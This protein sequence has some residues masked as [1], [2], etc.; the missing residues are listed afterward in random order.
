MTVHLA[1]TALE[2]DYAVTRR[3]PGEALPYW[4]AGPGLLSVTQAP[5][6]VSILCLADRVPA[7]EIA[8][9]GWQAVQVDT[10]A[11]LDQPRVVLAAVE[12][13]TRAGLG[14]FVTST[15]D[16]D[17]LLVRAARIAQA[18]AAWLAAGHRVSRGGVTLRL[19]G[20]DDA[21][22]L[23]CLHFRVWQETYARIA[24]PEVRLA[25]TKARRLAYWR[26]RLAQGGATV[27]AERAGEAVALAALSP[28]SDLE[29][30]GDA[31]ELNHLYVATE[32]RRTGLGRRLLTI[33]RAM[34][35][36]QDGRGLVLAVVRENQLALAFYAGQ[37]GRVLAERRDKG[38]LWPS[39]NLIL[40]WE[41]AR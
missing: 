24:P 14:I 39:D 8:A 16:R 35:G 33:A 23:A 18:E 6:E 40:G 27:I 29:G 37:G 10:C 20:P 12:P 30:F 5:D 31:M 19:A 28:A 15:H 1:L 3:A 9:R 2:G 11:A 21:E 17:Y 34:A 25:L 32:A 36:A 26:D 41:A 13:V 22:A 38:P 7:E 4:I